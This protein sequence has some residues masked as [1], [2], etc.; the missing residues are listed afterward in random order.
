MGYRSSDE[1]NMATWLDEAE[2]KLTSCI[3]PRK[4]Y[5]SGKWMFFEHAYKTTRTWTGPGDPVHEHRW[6][7]KNEYLMWR[8]KLS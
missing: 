4:C 1:M 2:V 6:Y 7:S 5:S 8:I 3:W